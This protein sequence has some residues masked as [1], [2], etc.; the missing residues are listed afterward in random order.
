MSA[1]G[2]ERPSLCGWLA[3]LLF[4]PK[5]V[6]CGGLLPD[7]VR[8]LCP[9]C[10]RDLPWC[11]GQE[12]LRFGETFALCVSPLHYRDQ[13]RT[14]FHRYKFQGQS[15]Y[16]GPYGRLMARCIQTH[17][18]GQYDLITWVPLSR[19]RRRARGY[20]QAMLLAEAA[21]R[22]LDRPVAGT[23]T[24]GRHTAAQSGLDREEDR[25]INIRGAYQI[26]DPALVR[27]KRLLLVDDIITTGS[28]LSEAAQ[29]LYGAGAVKIF[30]AALARAH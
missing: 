30:C 7:G 9:K 13:V 22:A 3:D 27:G 11:A 15:S 6:F 17:L 20:D 14:S 24:K 12:A 8:D 29:T 23:L 21:G 5:C 28:T 10:Q 16:A 26:A 25:R 2:G 19:R 1:A 18:D 4:P